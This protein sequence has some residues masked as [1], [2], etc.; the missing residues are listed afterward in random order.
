M[1]SA[2]RAGGHGMKS[3]SI[4]SKTRMHR[5]AKSESQSTLTSEQYKRRYRDICTN[6]LKEIYDGTREGDVYEIADSLGSPHSEGSVAGAKDT[7]MPGD[8]RIMRANSEDISTGVGSPLSSTYFDVS[9]YGELSRQLQDLISNNSDLG[10]RLLSLLLVS[11]GNAEEIINQ[12]NKKGGGLSKLPDVKFANIQVSKQLSN[13]SLVSGCSDV[14]CDHRRISSEDRQR[15]SNDNESTV[16]VND[17]GTLNS[18]GDDEDIIRLQMEKRKR[19]TEAS[20]RFRIRKK[21]REQEKLSKLRQLNVEISGMYKR[22]D[23]LMEENKFWKQKLEEVNERK[24]K[25][26]LDTIKRRNKAANFE[27]AN[28]AK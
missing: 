7:N 25:E 3:T 24:S 17:S 8:Y 10:S 14:P 9:R 15:G 22:I 11:T 27:S 6:I 21:L 13:G 16:T 2:A 19:N 18:E 23:E 26:V 1:I 5:N 20:A 28:N 12:I 4:T